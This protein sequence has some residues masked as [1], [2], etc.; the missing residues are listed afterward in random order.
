MLDAVIFYVRISRKIEL[1]GGDG[2]TSWDFAK[3][4]D[5]YTPQY[6]QSASIQ[7]TLGNTSYSVLACVKSTGYVS[8]RMNGRSNPESFYISGIYQLH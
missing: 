7:W 4:P 5:A 6:T 8:M 2:G 3:L 1:D